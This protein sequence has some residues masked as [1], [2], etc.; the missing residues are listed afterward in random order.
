MKTRTNSILIRF[1]HWAME[2]ALQNILSPCGCR[3][4]QP[5]HASFQTVAEIARRLGARAIEENM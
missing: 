4:Y 2:C 5:S 3:H 1:R